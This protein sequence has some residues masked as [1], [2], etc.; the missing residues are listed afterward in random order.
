M[1]HPGMQSAKTR[2]QEILKASDLFS[3]TNKW[4]GEKR[5][6]GTVIKEPYC[7]L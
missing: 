1:T 5:K 3:S 2:M 6:Q 7:S 4:Q